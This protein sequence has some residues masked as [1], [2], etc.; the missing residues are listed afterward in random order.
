MGLR[1]LV[2]GSD[3]YLA[4]C[5]GC[6]TILVVLATVE[7][8]CRAQMTPQDASGVTSCE[9]ELASFQAVLGAV[10]TKKA[11]DVVP[12]A[13]VTAETDRASCA[14]RYRA[15]AG[16]AVVQCDS[17]T[18]LMVGARRHSDSRIRTIRL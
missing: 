11:E 17:L 8:V 10:G 1:S 9:T 13:T 15:F 16:I 5:R 3:S 12:L 2:V 18:M 4:R 6:A 7:V 14:A